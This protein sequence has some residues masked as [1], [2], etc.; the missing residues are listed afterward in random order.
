[1]RTRTTARKDAV[2]EPTPYGAAAEAVPCLRCQG[3]PYRA[4]E[5][6]SVSS[7]GM[8]SSGRTGNSHPRLDPLLP[9]PLSLYHMLH[10]VTKV[11]RP[12]ICSKRDV[13][14]KLKPN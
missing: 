9:E 12:K 6:E 10:G 5:D 13:K 1:M 11:H 14:T 2:R 4:A 7:S 3:E 8:L